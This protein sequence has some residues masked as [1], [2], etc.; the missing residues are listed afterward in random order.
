[1]YLKK[2]LLSL[3][4]DFVYIIKKSFYRKYKINNIPPYNFYINDY[5]ESNNKFD[6]LCAKY[7]TDKGGGK[8][9]NN[10][11]KKNYAFEWHPHN[12]AQVYEDLFLDIREKKMNI[13]EVGIGSNNQNILGNMGAKAVPGASLR[14][15][16]NYFPNS[17]IY[18]ADIDKNI[19]FKTR[20]IKTF[21]LDQTKKKD[22]YKLFKKINK[23]MDIIIDDGLHSF[24]ANISFFEGSL[25]FLKKNGFFIIE[26]VNEFNMSK[27]YNYFSK[28][29]LKVN[30]MNIFNKNF[31]GRSNNLII[32]RNIKRN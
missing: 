20:S 18:G 26:D 10:G 23:K 6:K 12:Y 3:Y 31:F 17:L 19:L 21:Y 16:K 5:I 15:L 9:L 30:V 4:R 28:T 8:L 13:F 29:N 25:N 32:I 27:Y 24:E 2:K 7:K 22:V 14:V 1:M 11:K